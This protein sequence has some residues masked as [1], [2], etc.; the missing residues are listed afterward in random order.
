M[1]DF[2]QYQFIQNAFIASILIGIACGIVG[3]LVVIQRITFISAGIGHAALGGLG[4]GYFLGYNLMLCLFLFSL[5]CSVIVGLISRKCNISEDSIISIIWSAGMA[6]GIVL[7]DATPGYAPDLFAY[8]FG[9][10]LTVSNFDLLLMLIVD[11][12]VVFVVFILYKEF[13][14]IAF[15]EEYAE[16]SRLPVTTL[17]IVLLSLVACSVVIL[18]RAVGMILVITL[19]TIPALIAKQFTN[20]LPIMM[21]VSSLIGTTLVVSGLLS[22]YLFDVGSGSII[23]L[24]SVAC[25]FSVI[26]YKKIKIKFFT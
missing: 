24:L 23:V 19:L 13:F 26:T 11:C 9:N 20:R 21:F 2:F 18:I 10:I 7:I 16:Y 12:V 3:S 1:F 4:L 14:A 6:F 17:Y 5:L 22:S 15:D 8:L 25:F